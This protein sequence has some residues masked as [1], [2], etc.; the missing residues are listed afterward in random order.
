MSAKYCNIHD[1][2]DMIGAEP[3]PI[4]AK[5]VEFAKATMI[6]CDSIEEAVDTL[7]LLDAADEIRPHP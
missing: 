1:Y 4:D 6:M 2:L 5:A 7:Q 3:P